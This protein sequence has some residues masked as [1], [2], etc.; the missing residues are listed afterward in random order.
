MIEADELDGQAAVQVGDLLEVVGDDVEVVV[1]FGEDV[2]VRHVADA[3]AGF[4]EVHLPG[5]FGQHVAA[6]E[7]LAVEGVAP[8]DFDFE[9]AGEGVDDGGAD[10]VEAAGD[11]VCAAAELAA[12]V[13]G[14]HDGFEG[15][16]AGGGVDVHGDAAPVVADG[17]GAVLAD[18]DFNA[19]AE[20]RHCLV[21][22]VV[23]DFVDEVVEAALVRAADVHAGAAADGL[24]S[25]KDGDVLGGVSGL[26]LGGH[27][28]SIL[29]LD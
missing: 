18:G 13:E 24:Q 7:G 21:H 8:A 9:M 2:L 12:G 28:W 16:H 27:V 25:F 5:H 11:G 19:G 3:R 4:A 10:A 23:D 6:L 1:E 20:S 22:G 17:N 26:R 15:G 29:Y 14:G